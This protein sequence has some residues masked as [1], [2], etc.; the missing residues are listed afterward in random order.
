LSAHAA[1]GFGPEA[2]HFTRVED[3]LAEVESVLAPDITVLVK[4][5]RYMQ[6]ERVVKAFAID[7]EVREEKREEARP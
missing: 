4:G 1:R 3:L 7:G 6:M 5:S 2:R